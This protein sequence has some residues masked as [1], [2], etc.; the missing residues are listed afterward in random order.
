MGTEKSRKKQEREIGEAN[1]GEKLG[2]GGLHEGKEGN[3]FC[4]RINY[5]DEN[6]TEEGGCD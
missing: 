5:E 2:K 1:G 4:Q 3:S 6:Q